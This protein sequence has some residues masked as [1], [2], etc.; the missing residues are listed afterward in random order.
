[1]N[2]KMSMDSAKVSKI[3]ISSTLESF[4][5]SFWEK[6]FHVGL[7]YIFHD[8]Y[9]KGQAQVKN[10]E[11]NPSPA[12]KKMHPSTIDMDKLKQ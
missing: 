10:V 8:Y 5:L 9:V 4:L 2:H 7:F 11:G 1:M 12:L 3:S 6:E